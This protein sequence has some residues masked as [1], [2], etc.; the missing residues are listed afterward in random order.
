MVE[1]KSG[2]TGWLRKGDEVSKLREVASVIIVV[3]L[4]Y[5]YFTGYYVAEYQA[6]PKEHQYPAQYQEYPG[7]EGGE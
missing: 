3:F 7:N 4:A 2:I 1:D 5:A 6:K